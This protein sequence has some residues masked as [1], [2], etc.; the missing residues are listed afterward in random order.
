MASRGAIAGIQA[1]AL[2]RVEAATAAIVEQLGITAPRAAPHARQPELREA[3]ELERQADLL[4]QIAASTEQRTSAANEAL[5]ARVAQLETFIVENDLDVPDAPIAE[6]EPDATTP[7]GDQD[8]EGEPS[9]A[10]DPGHGDDAPV[11]GPPADATGDAPVAPDYDAM[12]YADL[13]ALAEQRG[14]EPG[15]SKASA[16]EALRTADAIANATVAEV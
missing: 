6:Q 9:D 8:S 13:R 14:V 2:K 12:S 3:W 7:E 10:A 11:A 15:R 16:I 1:E 4:E 5:L